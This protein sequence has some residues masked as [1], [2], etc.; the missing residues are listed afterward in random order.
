NNPR[1]PTSGRASP[2]V[3]SLRLDEDA[4]PDEVATSVVTL[5]VAAARALP[6]VTQDADFDPLDGVAGL[7]I[8]RV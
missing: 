5:A 7:Q 2:H 3:Q 6:V 8:I 1:V 4:I